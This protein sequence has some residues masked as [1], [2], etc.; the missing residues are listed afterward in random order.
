MQNCKSC[1]M[2]LDEQTRYKDTDYCVYCGPEQEE[3]EN[4]EE[5]DEQ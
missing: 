2:P 4:L 3:E 1:Q 5:T